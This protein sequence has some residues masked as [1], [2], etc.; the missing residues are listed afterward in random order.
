MKYIISDAKYIFSD[1]K[2]IISVWKYIISD[3]KYIIGVRKYIIG[4]RKYIVGVRKYN[5]SVWKY[6]YS[7]RKYNKG[8]C[9]Y[10]AGFTLNELRQSRSFG[11]DITE[12]FKIGRF[13]NNF[14]SMS[15][16]SL[17]VLCKTKGGWVIRLW[18][19]VSKPPNRDTPKTLEVSGGTY[20][21]IQNWALR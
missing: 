16:N 7:V 12:S 17:S 14:T 3:V 8:S 18:W 19:I 20:R 6:R 9:A 4:V 11:R 15:W 1:V 5:I 13:G 10:F 2:Y 21:I